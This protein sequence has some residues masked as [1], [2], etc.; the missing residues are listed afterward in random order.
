MPIRTILVDDHPIFLSGLKEILSFDEEIEIIDLAN[1]AS[2]GVDKIK[3]QRPDIAIIDFDMPGKNAITLLREFDTEN[4]ST[5]FIVLTMHKAE[6]IYNAVLNEGAKG[7]I[8]KENSIDDLIEGIHKV[9]SGDFYVSP[10]ID[11]YWKNRKNKTHQN[12]LAEISK[13]EWRILVKIAEGC[14]N[15]EIAEQLFLSKKTIESHRSN[16]ITKLDLE[17]KNSLLKFALMNKEIILRE[18][19]IRS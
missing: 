2:I 13:A 11:S 7:F 4:I 15:Q 12:I 16:M 8:L 6:D 19:I 3:A 14:S 5:K 18:N 1:D 17:G 10:I 9:H